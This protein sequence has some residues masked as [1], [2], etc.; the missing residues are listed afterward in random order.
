MAVL[1]IPVFGL[2]FCVDLGVHEDVGFTVQITSLSACENTVIAHCVYVSCCL[3][4]G[5]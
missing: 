2:N 5:S 3:A 4:A 1:E